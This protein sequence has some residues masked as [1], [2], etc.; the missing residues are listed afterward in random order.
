MDYWMDP[1]AFGGES[2]APIALH[3]ARRLFRNG[4]IAITPRPESRLSLAFSIRFASEGEHVRNVEG[5]RL[6]VLRDQF[7]VCS[8]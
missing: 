6:L 1:A 4:W 2:D 3:H 5:H 7:V 8:I